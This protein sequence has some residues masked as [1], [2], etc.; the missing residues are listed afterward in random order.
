MDEYQ[1]LVSTLLNS[2]IGLKRYQTYVVTRCVKSSSA[3]PDSLLA[4]L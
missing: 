3:L 2:N 1:Q 4:T